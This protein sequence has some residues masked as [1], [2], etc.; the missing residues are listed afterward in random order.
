VEGVDPQRPFGAYA[1]LTADVANSPVV[2]MI[3]I[4]DE[5]RFLQMLRERLS[6]EPEKGDD[7]TLKASLPLINEVVLRFA[8]G[9]LYVGRTAKD[10]DRKT[11]VTPKAFFANDDGAVD[12]QDHGRDRPVV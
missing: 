3:P 11:L 1:V 6:V 5:K 9:Y 2:I 8:D 4:A 10:L 12:P 7:G